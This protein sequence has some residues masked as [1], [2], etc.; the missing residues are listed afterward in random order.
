MIISEGNIMEL[1]KLQHV[2]YIYIHNIVLLHFWLFKLSILFAPLS[3][4]A[5]IQ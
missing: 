4:I 3:S 1:S 2:S 5:P